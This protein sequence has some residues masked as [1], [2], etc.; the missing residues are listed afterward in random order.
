MWTYRRE[1]QVLKEMKKDQLSGSHNAKYEILHLIIQRKIVDRKSIGRSRI[2]W[3]R[4]L[5]EW[6]NRCSADL[7]RTAVSKVRIAMMLSNP[8]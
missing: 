5:R 7:F 1:L 6:F 2:F 8:R 3:L 4:N